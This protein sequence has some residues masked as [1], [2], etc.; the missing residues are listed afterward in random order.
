MRRAGVTFDFGQTLCDL[1]TSMLAC[2]LRERGV[3]VD[4]SVLEAKV[5]EAWAAYDA[6][7][8]DGLGGH[9]WKILM[10]R[11]LVLSGAPTDA[12]VRAVDFLWTEQ[13]KNNL[14]RR[15]VA[16]MIELVRDLRASGTVV[17]VVSNSEGHLA[18]L[19]SEL[20]WQEYF[21]VVA[22]SG[23]LG[24]EKPDA[25]IFRYAATQL[26]VPLSGIVHVGDS[27]A[28]DVQGALGCGMRA[29]WFRGRGDVL[30]PPSLAVAGDAPGVRRALRRFGIAA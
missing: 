21:T 20:G 2:R 18:E 6:A 29:V 23:R 4:A 15:P 24:V 25:A 22:D 13:P 26:G 14:W 28:A 12:A 3:R 1:D 7:I 10:N 19:C 5:A 30:P 9:P 8:R 11:L 16:G 27:F 17:G